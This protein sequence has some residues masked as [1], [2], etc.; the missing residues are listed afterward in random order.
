MQLLPLRRHLGLACALSCLLAAIPAQA[1]NGD[2]WYQVE[3]LVFSQEDGASA[4]EWEALPALAYPDVYRFLVYPSLVTARQERHPGKSQLD[5]IGRQLI[6]LEDPNAVPETGPEPDG[7]VA[8]QTRAVGDPKAPESTEGP[9]PALVQEAPGEPEMAIQEQP[10]LPTPFIALPH[11]Q[12]TLHG[13]SAY[14]QRTGR[15]RT[16]FHETWV[17]PV[18]AEADALPLIVDDSGVLQDWPRLQGS[19]KLYLSRYLH[20]ETNL[21]LNTSGDYLPGAW[22]MPAAPLG[23]AS[24]IVEEPVTTQYIEEPQP[25]ISMPVPAPPEAVDAMDPNSIEP[26]ESAPVYPWRHAVLMR[27]SRRMRSNELHYLDHPLLGVV[28]QLTPL[29]K[30]QLAA[31][32]R[33]ETAAA[34]AP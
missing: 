19:V 18:P 28:V 16:L 8:A 34:D 12:R 30:E 24:L 5:A 27:Q 6:Q 13:K 31:M 11:Q 3:L 21:W 23:P 22:R 7:D 9:P 25:G 10:L 33:A 4:E 2:R 26:E 14:M 32:A 1:Q 29:D 20:I 15:F 17:Q